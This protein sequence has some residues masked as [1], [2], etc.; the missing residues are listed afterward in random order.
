LGWSATYSN[1]VAP[2]AAA[3]GADA[4][5]CS[6][7]AGARLDPWYPLQAANQA[8]ATGNT[9]VRRTKVVNVMAL[10]FFSAS[11]IACLRAEAIH[12]RRREKPR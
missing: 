9:S 2:G 8:M 11:A 1:D 6:A 10:L 12:E 3:T 5:G 4:L 7:G